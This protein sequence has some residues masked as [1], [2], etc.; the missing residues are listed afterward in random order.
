MASGSR[1]SAGGQSAW[2]AR[3]TPARVA[4]PRAARSEGVS[5]SRCAPGWI[6]AARSRTIGS[7]RT[8]SARS[9]VGGP[10]NEDH[11]AEPEKDERHEV[12]AD[13]RERD[14]DGADDQQDRP[15]EE[16]PTET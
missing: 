9:P 8:P 2:L 5:A 15:E 12:I 6:G 16:L 14:V 10:A 13:A 1:P 3:V 7:A 4:R 11:C